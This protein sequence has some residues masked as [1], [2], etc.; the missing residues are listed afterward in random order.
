MKNKLI[1]LFAFLIAELFPATVGRI[2][3]IAAYLPG[4]SAES[5]NNNRWKIVPKNIPI[6]VVIC[7]DDQTPGFSFLNNLSFFERNYVQNFPFDFEFDFNEEFFPVIKTSSLRTPKKEFFFQLTGSLANET[8]DPMIS[9]YND[10]NSKQNVDRKAVIYNIFTGTNQKKYSLASNIILNSVHQ[11]DVEEYEHI[12]YSNT[13]FRGR[14]DFS[15]GDL[16]F[17]SKNIGLTAG[18]GKSEAFF[19]FHPVLGADIPLNVN[20]KR[21]RTDLILDDWKIS[22]RVNWEDYEEFK[23]VKKL[24]VNFKSI[25]R[26]LSLK[27]DFSLFNRKIKHR[28]SLDFYNFDDGKKNCRLAFISESFSSVFKFKEYCLTADFNPGYEK[29]IGFL[30]SAGIKLKNNDF[31]EFRWFYTEKHPFSINHFNYLLTQN[32][33]IYEHEDISQKGKIKSQKT[34]FADVSLKKKSGF[35]TLTCLPSI[36]YSDDLCYVDYRYAYENKLISEPIIY[37]NEH[38]TLIGISDKI[39]IS[40][41]GIDLEFWHYAQIYAG[42]SH[43]FNKFIRTKRPFWGINC[44]YCPFEDLSFDLNFCRRPQEKIYEFRYVNG[45]P[46]NYFSD[47]VTYI[48]SSLKSQNL[49]SLKVGKLFFDNMLLVS[50]NFEHLLQE[51]EP[52]HPRGVRRDLTVWVNFDF[53]SEIDLLN[54]DNEQTENLSSEK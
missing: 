41:T 33:D 24:G 30:K 21:L 53:L 8:K 22:Y 26:E 47:K 19:F 16:N 2:F 7:V 38:G 14:T 35:L 25:N 20:E 44:H 1:I 50:F 52:F 18:T 4:Y 43:I 9:G 13:E 15:Y 12:V 49:L 28:T 40:L 42:G 17:K 11:T 51:S 48:E 31:Y 34:Y 37:A 32:T 23:P 10:D 39:K 3:D 36:S 46:N 27:K 54:R 5:I 29:N 45:I 6:P